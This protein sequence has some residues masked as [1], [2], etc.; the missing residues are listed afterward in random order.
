MTE[1][2]T[3]LRAE[4]ERA[5]LAARLANPE[6]LSRAVVIE[7]GDGDSCL[8]VPL[9]G[10]RV[11]G[12]VKVRGWGPALAVLEALDGRPGFPYLRDDGFHG[13]G[14]D[15]RGDEPR[16]IVWG[17]HVG[18]RT[19]HGARAARMWGFHD[20]GVDA[21]VTE[22]TW[23]DWR[24][25]VTPVP[26]FRTSASSATEGRVYYLLL[27]G[28]ENYMNDRELVFSFSEDDRQALA[29]AAIINRAHL[30]AVVKAMASRG[31]DQYLDLG[32]GFPIRDDAPRK[33]AP[34]YPVLHEL[35]AQE[36]GEA[37]RVV[38]VDRD[39]TLFAKAR[40]YLEE[41]P[42]RPEWVSADITHMEQFL[43]SGRVQ[44]VLDWKR[45]IGVL[46]HDVLPWI[47]DDDVV[48]E[49]VALPRQRLAPG[50]ALSI[51]HASDF[52]D[53][54]R[55]S[56]FTTPFRKAGLG[57]KPRTARDIGGLF[58]KWPLEAP[59]IVPPHRW[60]S[61]HPYADWEYHAAGAFA[62]LALKPKG[63]R[64]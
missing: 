23:E 37:A 4:R 27:G 17:L 13:V 10:S 43:S 18:F 45:P 1:N 54:N 52:G 53:E 34:P 64:A 2:S 63:R 51:T 39:R 32:C 60:H 9:G 28:T 61:E 5:E 49:A 7:L 19:D 59:G 31:I 40:I 26:S 33:G 21:Y 29:A 11:A 57:F 6:L 20:A 14:D 46:L 41:D 42:R 50:S 48:A 36:R 3:L 38:Y 56:R 30:P 55:M 35:A 47:A 15:D 24:V 62:G 12:Q 22:Q 25:P 8:A 44:R 58:G 16:A